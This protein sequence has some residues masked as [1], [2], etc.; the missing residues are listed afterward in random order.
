MSKRSRYS[1]EEKHDILRLYDDGLKSGKEILSEYGV[2][3]RTLRDWRYQFLNSG[4][5]GLV[6]SKSINRYSKELKMQIVNEV[7]SG[8]ISQRGAARKY[9]ISNKGTIQNWLKKYNGF[10]EL[11]STPKGMTC[12]MAKVRPTN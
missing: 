2:H 1:A 9:G 5:E 7:L 10:R 11:K 12:S 3:N 6:E 8:E 4:I